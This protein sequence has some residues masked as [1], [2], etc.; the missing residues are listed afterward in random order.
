M[1]HASAGGK[2][3]E[4]G[5]VADGDVAISLPVRFGA[6]EL[7]NQLIE[8]E[9]LEEFLGVLNSKIFREDD[10]SD[11]LFIDTEVSIIAS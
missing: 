2:V 5:P 10:F 1:G 9:S 8:N 4:V 3:T 11:Q 7:K 6:I